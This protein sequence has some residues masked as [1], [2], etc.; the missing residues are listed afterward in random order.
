MA[1]KVSGITVV[2]DSKDLINVR[3][4]DSTGIS[5]LGQTVHVDNSSSNPIITF[6]GNTGITSSPLVQSNR[7]TVGS[8]ITI[9]SNGSTV[10]GIT[11]SGI[12]TANS[13]VGSGSSLTGLTG[14]SAGTYGSASQVAQITV[15][16]N[17]RITNIQN[18]SITG[19]GGGGSTTEGIGTALSSDV[20]SI[21]S[22]IYRTPISYT[23]ADNT[24]EIVQSDPGSNNF[25][26]T[27]LDQ[28]IVGSGAVLEI[29]NGTT[30]QMNILNIF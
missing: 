15:D 27:K 14:A 16:S 10:G 4:I 7:V 22:I 13:Y 26:Y 2:N 5:T 8:A 25:A 17:N 3:N 11:V 1:L 20:N 29:A 23:I 28:I 9:S 19:G 21:L 24:T 18:V 30:L 12:V 6:D